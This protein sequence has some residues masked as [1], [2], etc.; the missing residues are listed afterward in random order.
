MSVDQTQP[1][2]LEPTGHS[3]AKRRRGLL[4]LGL[5]SAFVSFA[6]MMQ[7]GLNDNFL[8]EQIGISALQKGVLEAVRESCGIA[9]LGV[10]ALCAGL[11]EPL[12]GAI[13]LILFGAGLALYAVVEGFTWTL[14]AYSL[15]WSQGLHVWMP[16]PQSMVLSLAEPG[17]TGRRMG[18]IRSAGS[19]GAAAGLGLALL[20]TE[21]G[22]PIRPLWLLAGGAACL[23]AA[24][25]LGIPRDIKTPGPRLVF[26]RKYGLFYLLSVLEGWRKQIFIA[27]AGFLLVK[28]H[29]APLRHILTLWLVVQS[30]G[31]LIAPWVGR[32]IDRLGE[33]RILTFYFASLT[34]FFVGYA[35]ITDTRLLYGLF[36]I[37]NLFFVFA[38]ALATY[39]RRIA[40]PS[41]HTPTLAMGVA[42]NHV[43]AVAMPLAGGLLWHFFGYRWAF[44]AG[45]GAAAVSILAAL[46]L[47]RHRPHDP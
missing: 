22:V 47:P 44:L 6:I 36:V 11:A 38:M 41:E 40:P 1:L 27:F 45:A 9:A 34:L 20:L 21:A 13:M 42:M 28:I 4:F 3:H 8:V 12:L 43:A 32:L 7:I 35:T 37:D 16:L 46:R 23:G 17:R 39:V 14:I 33:R 5:A 30:L 24:A 26:R 10:L 19:V 29:G 15:L 2:Q 18:Q 31:W 25:C